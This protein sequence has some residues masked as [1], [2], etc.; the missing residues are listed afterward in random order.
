M[1]MTAQLS[2]YSAQQLQIMNQLYI[3]TSQLSQQKQ[4]AYLMGANTV[5]RA[6]SDINN[7]ENFKT[8][9]ACITDK[10]VKQDLVIIRD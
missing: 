5:Y 7:S 2:D 8:Y 4:H 10:I 1:K 9:Q 6:Q 3:K